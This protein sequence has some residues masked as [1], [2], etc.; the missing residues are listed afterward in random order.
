MV[1]QQFVFEDD[2]VTLI[3]S[4]SPWDSDAFGSQIA[5]IETFKFASEHES[6]DWI[7]PLQDW[8]DSE[9]IQLV[10]CRLPQDALRESMAIERFGFRFIEMVLHPFLPSISSERETR[11]FEAVEA[12]EEDIDFLSAVAFSAFKHER[13][14]LDHRVADF[15]ASTRYSNWVGN[16]AN[17]PNQRLLKILDPDGGIAGFVIYEVFPNN[18]V[19]WALTALA[20]SH[21]G[22]GIGEYAWN[23]VINHNFW[24]GFKSITTTIAARNSPVIRLYGKLGFK[25]LPPE[26]TFHWVATSAQVP[27]G[28]KP[29]DD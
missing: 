24:S 6:N 7:E 21:R 8:L 25:Y 19:K 12:S 27:I 16:I 10:S 23:S 29:L 13:F 28:R 9:D 15:V 4:I 11:G 26:I 5:S 22:K 14:H 20:E 3:A 1:N 2:Q 18:K 17:Y